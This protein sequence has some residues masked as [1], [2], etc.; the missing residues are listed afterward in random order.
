MCV[1]NDLEDVRVAQP[2]DFAAGFRQPIP[3][4]VQVPSGKGGCEAQVDG[5]SGRTPREDGMRLSSGRV[6]EGQIELSEACARRGGLSIGHARVL[7][8]MRRIMND[9]DIE[10]AARQPQLVKR[11]FAHAEPGYRPGSCTAMNEGDHGQL[12]VDI[13]A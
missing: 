1:G 5:P 9:V 4:H 2:H 12:R 7:H 11:K 10:A 13:A 8:F 6:C 3:G